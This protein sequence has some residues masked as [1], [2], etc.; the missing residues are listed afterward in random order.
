MGFR[1]NL[2]W[3]GLHLTDVAAGRTLGGQCIAVNVGT[4]RLI[5]RLLNFS[6]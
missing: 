2:L 5:T 1:Q 4:G 3:L 6:Q